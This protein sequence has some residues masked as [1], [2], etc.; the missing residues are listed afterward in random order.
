MVKTL[1][2]NFKSGETI[3]DEDNFSLELQKI[4]QFLTLLL[5]IE[6]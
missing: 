3:R 2:G 1:F 5:T 6:V 4:I